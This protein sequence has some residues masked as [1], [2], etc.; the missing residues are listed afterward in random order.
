MIK[1]P[2]GQIFHK[3]GKFVKHNSI[4]DGVDPLSAY[5]ITSSNGGDGVRRL[6]PQTLTNS[7]SCSIIISN[8]DE[9]AKI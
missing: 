5:L 4:R 2:N 6:A 8:E 7:K 9:A 1:T 3:N